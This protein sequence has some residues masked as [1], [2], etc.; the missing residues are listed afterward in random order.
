[1]PYGYSLLDYS[2]SWNNYLSTIDNNG[3]LWRS[4]GDTE[5]HRLNL[6]H[7]LFRNGDIKTGVSVGLSHRINHN[8]L[9]DL[10]LQSSNRKLTSLLFGLSHTQKIFG[11][12][13]TFNP[14]FSRGWMPNA[15]A[16]KAAT[17]RKPSSVNG[18]LTPA[19]S[20]RWQTIC[21]GWRAPTG[22]GRRTACTAV[23]A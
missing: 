1:M 9:D 11:G 2:Y 19:S 4:S 12:V 14:T 23:S 20:A 21:G 18:A 7:V 16:I 8:Y 17:C 15:M 6:S 5:T 3:Y 10:L 13:A 22:S